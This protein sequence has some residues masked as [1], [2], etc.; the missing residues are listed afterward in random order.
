AKVVLVPFALAILLAFILAPPVR[1]L[2]HI[3]LPRLLA[4]L[5][6]VLL[7]MAAVGT[8]G[9]V[10]TNQFADAVSEWPKYRLNIKNKIESIRQ[11]KPQS[12]NTAAQAVQEISTDLQATTVTPA[13]VS[14]PAT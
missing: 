12:L 1:W 4:V 3:H 9:W 6:V 10:V 13:P 11:S 14:A 2:E 8:V 5:I 7:L